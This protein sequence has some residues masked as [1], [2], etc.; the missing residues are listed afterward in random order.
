MPRLLSGHWY[1]L[2]ALQI[3][4]G[5]ASWQWYVGR[6]RVA[7]EELWG[8]LALLTV[9]GIAIVQ[10]PTE[11]PLYAPLL[12]PTILLL[13]YA[14][15]YHALYPLARAALLMSALAA[16]VSAFH[17]RTRLQPGI[18][19]LALLALPI[20]PSLQFFCGFPLRVL[21]ANLT[22]WLLRLSGSYVLAEGTALK[23]GHTLIVVDAPCSGVRMLW[24]G[25]FLACAMA[26][27]FRFGWRDTLLALGGTVIIIVL[28]N[29]LRAAALF[30]PEAG[31]F[32]LPT[33][34]HDGVGILVFALTAAGI[35]GYL[36]LLQRR[37]VCAQ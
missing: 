26:A 12:L 25:C 30:F 9:I 8:L 4:C 20:I 21:V 10:P 1:W 24:T 36:H 13:A 15:G 37:R 17:F 16:T 5:W 2:L 31:V 14:L 3:C 28:G 7:P 27:A 35:A 18:W 6:V 29:A 19:C 34:G 23:W 33:G 32:P 22:A 11:K